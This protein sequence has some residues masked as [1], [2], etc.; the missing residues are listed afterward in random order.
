MIFPII[1]HSFA[2]KIS[3]RRLFDEILGVTYIPRRSDPYSKSPSPQPSSFREVQE[4]SIYYVSPKIASEIVLAAGKEGEDFPRHT[5]LIFVT[6]SS[7]AF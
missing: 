2:K 4:C 6:D 1:K 3:V 5:R 7:Q